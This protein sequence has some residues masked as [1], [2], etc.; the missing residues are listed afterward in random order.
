MLTRQ[1]KMRLK[2]S[3]ST[4]CWCLWRGF[5]KWQFPVLLS[6]V[7]VDYF[8]FNL[9]PWLPELESDTVVIV[10]VSTEQSVCLFMPDRLG[11][12]VNVFRKGVQRRLGEGILKLD[13]LRLDKRVNIFRFWRNTIQGSKQVCLSILRHPEAL[14]EAVLKWHLCLPLLRVLGPLGDTWKEEDVENKLLEN[15][16]SGKKKR[17]VVAGLSVCRCFLV[18]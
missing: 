17:V 3:P 5:T 8:A 12:A 10:L 1:S 11:N 14:N 15:F 2:K 13:F 4:L 18:D 6:N 9:V 7:E 16:F